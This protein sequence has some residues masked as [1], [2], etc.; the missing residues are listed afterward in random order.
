MPILRVNRNDDGTATF[1]LEFPGVVGPSQQWNGWWDDATPWNAGTYQN[2]TLS[3]VSW[4]PND[5]AFLINGGNVPPGRT[6]VFLH[7]GSS[8][9]N[10]EGCLILPLAAINQ[11]LTTLAGSGASTQ[12]KQQAI[13]S[14]DLIVEQNPSLNYTFKP[15][16][17]NQ[18][19]GPEG[20]QFTVRVQIDGSNNNGISK[21]AFVHLNFSG[22]AKY[23]EDYKISANSASL[24]HTATAYSGT[25]TNGFTPPPSANDPFWVKIPEGQSYVDLVFDT[26]SDAAT[27]QTESV[28]I[29]IDDYFIRRDSSPD[30]K[31]RDA[32]KNQ[33]LNSPAVSYQITDKESPFDTLFQSGGQGTFVFD[34]NAAPDQQIGLYFN[35]YSIPDTMTISDLSTNTIYYNKTLGENIGSTRFENT[36]FKVNGNSTGDLRITITAPLGGTAWEFRLDS[37]GIDRPVA[38]PNPSLSMQ[39]ALA[40]DPGDTAPITFVTSQGG[41]LLFD[42]PAGWAEE[43]GAQDTVR[44]EILV[45][46]QS[47]SSIP[48][49]LKWVVDN[50]T[51]GSVN[52][53][54]F[55]GGIVPSGEFVVG[56]STSGIVDVSLLAD[57]LSE[58]VEDISFLFFF[59]DTNAPVLGADGSPLRITLGALD[60]ISF[61]PVSTRPFTDASESIVGTDGIDILFGGNGHDTIVGLD[62]NDSISGN[63]GA[64]S[65]LGGLGDDTIDPGFGDDYID[66]GAGID[67]LIFPRAQSDAVVTRLANGSFHVE[68]KSS[69]LPFG[70]KTLIGIETIQFSDAMQVINSPPA[71]T[72]GDS[73]NV[74]E[75]ATGT[76]YTISATDTDPGTVLSY[77]LA[78]PDA[79]WFTVN[80]TT[81]EITFRTAP[82]FE[83]P[84]DSGKNNVYDLVVTAS[85]GMLSASRALMITVEDIAEGP[86]DDFIGGLG[87][88]GSLS[89]GSA[90]NGSIQFVQDIDFLKITLEGGRTYE[91]QLLGADGE[92]PGGTLADAYLEFFD[93][94]GAFLQ[95]DDDSGPGL[96]S[97][98]TLSPSASGTF[99]LGVSDYNLTATGTYQ[100]LLTEVTFGGS[101]DDSRVGTSANDVFRTFGGRD[102]IRPLG[103]NDTVHGDD[104]VDRVIYDVDRSGNSLSIAADGSIIIQGPLIG[105]DNLYDVE[106]I[107]FIDGDFIFDVSGNQSAVVYRL[108][109]AAF[110][111]TPDEG[112]FRY[113]A[114]AADRFGIS[115]L[116]LASEFRTAPEFIQKYGANVSDYDYTYNM[117]RNVLGREPDSGGINYW[118]GQLTNRVVSRDQLLIEFSES[119]ENKYLTSPN[120][121]VGYWVV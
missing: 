100:L 58:G 55:L 117:Y 52:A 7:K 28:S 82:D 102:T 85:D 30:K 36:Q 27:E 6:A 110:A 50:S 116:S 22:S 43:E 32:P 121:D 19:N 64:D 12:E 4:A 18:T 73:A 48:V 41:S 91:A 31:Y 42:V 14:L 49:R 108:Y 99:F 46:M 93:A 109:Q 56:S 37:L 113:W 39:A 80:A 11:I 16:I 17:I 105:R 119:P 120:A 74:A 44:P 62:G 1:T 118:A 60:G 92:P 87:T 115:V 38:S 78:G 84:T 29:K 95:F 51:P 8:S 21:D 23:G 103:G 97:F 2:L 24:L 53:S 15:S 63:N 65:I 106:R 89:A 59:A 35:A 76:L 104:G 57:N 40:L 77:G 9:E 75:N 88:L 67:T 70:I 79:P 69:W 33:I 25:W 26:L 10:S 101:G 13:Q 94:S 90:V 61:T 5:P 34:L 66:G 68:D 45:S 114:D 81:G 111:R 47:G 86:A 71:I 98:L 96:S 112:G 83:I 20:S 54:D 107:D 3:A 72:S